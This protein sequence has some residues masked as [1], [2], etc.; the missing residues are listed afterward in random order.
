MPEGA[1]EIPLHYNHI[2]QGVIYSAVEPRLAAFLHDRGFISNGRSFKL[3]TFS[4]LNGRFEINKEKGSIRFLDE[5]SMTIS[6]PVSEFCNSVANGMLT[7]R[8]LDFGG[9]RVEA[10]NMI[11]RQHM[12]DKQQVR[13]KSLSPIVVYSTLLRPD[14]RKYTCY[15]QP[16]EPDYNRLISGNLRK[17]YEAYY[18]EEAPAED[19]KVEKLGQLNMHV[20]NYKKTV[21]KG[22]SGKLLLTGPSGL[23]QMAIDAGLGSKNSQ[24]FGCVEVV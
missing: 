22:Y 5:I 1:F 13:I 18:N 14:G 20:M 19:V 15:F 2:L 21:I 17:K 8:W 16:G 12:V 23:L 24:G 7:K 3:F 4:R 9:N 6:S 10:K 11:V